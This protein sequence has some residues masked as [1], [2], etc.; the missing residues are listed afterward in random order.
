M[1]VSALP[2]LMTALVT[3]AKTA[4]PDALVSLGYGIT[5]DAGDSLMVGVNDIDNDGAALAAQST[6]TPGPSGAQHLR[7]ESGSV[8]LAAYSWNGNGDA[9]Q[10]MTA[11]WAMAETVQ[12]LIKAD[13][14]LGVSVGRA[15]V[16]EY[17]SDHQFNQDQ[18]TQGAWALLVFAVSFNAY[19]I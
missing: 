5:D 14:T 12:T 4:M 7:D 18:T 1:A 3:Q 13:P 15:F 19:S 10:A 17:G 8:A 9:T 16:T 6:Q 11:V 2:T